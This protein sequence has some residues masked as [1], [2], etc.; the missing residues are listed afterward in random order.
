MEKT[1]NHQH[2]NTRRK[3][4][5]TE[6]TNTRRKSDAER[7]LHADTYV[8]EHHTGIYQTSNYLHLLFI[9]SFNL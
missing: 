5:A 7:H 1:E 4:D 3:S 6:H 8:K 2:T 9:F